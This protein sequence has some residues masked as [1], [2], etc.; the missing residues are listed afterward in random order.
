M[1]FLVYG[2]GVI[3]SIF[4]AKL[5]AAGFG[6]TVLARGRRYE[7]IAE[8]GIILKEVFSKNT[9][10]AKVGLTDRL[11]P[12]DVYDFILVA[13]QKAQAYEILPYLAQNGSK[14]IVFIVNNPSGFEEWKNAVGAKR[15][16]IGFPSA[17]G[18]RKDGVV[19][20]FIG[21]GLTRAF[22]TTTFGEYGGK[23]TDRLSA[24]V[25][26]FNKAGIPS[27]T[28]GNMD[29]WLKTHAAVVTSIAN[30]LYMYRSDNYRLARDKGTVRLMVRGIKEGLK[31][32][33]A[34]GYKITPFKL[35]YFKL[36][37]SIIAG[38]FK[39][40]MNTKIAE[41]A[42]AKH[43]I[44]AKGEMILLQKEFDELIRK[45]AVDTPA[46]NMLKVS[47]TE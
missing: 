38:I 26:A 42:M 21:R 9:Q 1:K 16:M 19:N 44:A 32:I 43:T 11:L 41:F 15:L 47:V 46:V 35:S 14:N 25:C 27:V 7:E 3:G 17:G 10:T 30:A 6:V 40:V 18:E 12:S 33:E 22:Q 5:A 24:L 31:A 45:S 28:N 2:A 37:G 8:N 39:I 23:K 4:A 36:P 29:A 20:C 34:L 13:M